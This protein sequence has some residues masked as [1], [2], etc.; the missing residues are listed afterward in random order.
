MGKHKKKGHH[1]PGM[2]ARFKAKA[3]G[4]ASAPMFIAA[5]ALAAAPLVAAAAPAL[6]NAGS[7]V[8]GAINGALQGISQN[9]VPI[10]IGGVAAGGAIVIGKGVAQ[11]GRRNLF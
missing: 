4:L 1:R 3:P 10:I 6:Q 9:A 2:I 5:V 7:D 8:V 11:L